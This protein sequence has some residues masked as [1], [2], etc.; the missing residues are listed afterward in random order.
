MRKRNPLL[1][2]LALCLTFSP[3]VGQNHP[4]RE[5]RGTWIHTVGQDRYAGMNQD[6]MKRYFITL[7]DSL[8]LAGVNTIIFQVR[9]EADAWYA[10]SIEPW[11]RYITGT[12]G[13]NPGWDPF[14]FLIREG[15]KRAMEVHA[16]INPY[17]VRTSPTKVLTPDHLYFKNRALFVEYG[18]YIWFDP[19]IP[20]S[21]EHI[22]KVV[23]DLVSRYDIDAVHIDDYFYPYPIAGKTFDDSQSFKKYG[24]P[25][26]YTEA[27]KADWRRDNVSELIKELHATVHAT[28]PWV[29]FGISP[30]GIYRNDP[31]GINGSKTKG[32]T[33]Y[34][35]LYAD[36]LLW[37]K[38][39]WVD[40]LMP[41]LYWEIGHK[42][43]DYLTLVHWW[44]ENHG[45]VPLYIGQDIVRTVKP[46]SSKKSQLWQKMQLAANEPSI[47]GHCFW[48]A[49]ELV[50][51]S[52]KIVDSLRLNYFKYPAL[53][54]ADNPYDK[55]PPQPVRNLLLSVSGNDR[56]LTWNEP[57]GTS[58]GDKAAYYVVYAFK[59][60]QPIN[61]EQ[62]SNIVGIITEKRMTIK[63]SAK[64]SIY[65]VTA[66]DRFHN[67]S[68]G[69]TVNT[70]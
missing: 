45:N 54:P 2:L 69:T 39:G 61:L 6:S 66:V 33:N 32:F 59:D 55:T 12:Q 29:E 11:S 22:L 62:A 37:V 15:H 19:G 14:D 30:F 67:E 34:D 65:V 13:K 7:L 16:W 5:F 60:G 47:S 63:S 18:E 20:A 27:T 3:L 42:S 44:A 4:K 10:S 43:A 40:Y 68:K 56:T 23:K 52:G 48:P 64:K 21:R 24:I 31:K 51:N 70:L 38:K 9:P 26:G 53:H 58:M 35:G 49:Y 57:E 46:D 50:N 28:K 17:R 36:I 41:Q 8:R 25:K 1:L